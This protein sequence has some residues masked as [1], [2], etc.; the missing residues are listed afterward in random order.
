[1]DSKT[2]QLFIGGIIIFALMS[3]SAVAQL[4]TPHQFY[5]S[6]TANGASAPDGL[7]ITAKVD[8][9]QVAD[10]TTLGGDYGRH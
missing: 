1:M 9:I 4:G 7:I 5:G 10:T 2:F 8:G 6:V 3:T